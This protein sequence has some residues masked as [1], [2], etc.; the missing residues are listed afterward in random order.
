M[1]T[2]KIRKE[3]G[4]T[5]IELLIVVGIIAILAAAVIITVTPGERLK[6][7]RDATRAANMAAIG[8][9]L[10]VGVVDGKI[11]SLLDSNCV[12]TT[13]YALFTQD[14]ATVVAMGSAPTDPQS[15][16]EYYTMATTVGG[17]YRVAVRSNPTTDATTT[18]VF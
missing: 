9:G 13:S 8:T 11:N 6:E 10:H 15:G 7:A 3:K 12:A 4:F 17:T 2:E 1:N 5:L 14:C 16:N 18:K